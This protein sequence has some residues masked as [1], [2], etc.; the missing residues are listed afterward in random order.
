MPAILE[1]PYYIHTSSIF[2]L[3]I[4]D[5]IKSS[6]GSN[7]KVLCANPRKELKKI[8]NIIKHDVC[9]I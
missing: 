2:I 1:L 9:H 8:M 4:P 5:K 7:L 6:L 3:N